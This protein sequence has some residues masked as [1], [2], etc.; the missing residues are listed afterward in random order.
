M[1]V[2]LLYFDGCPSVPAAREVLR[3]ALGAAGLP[4]AFEEV[5][6][7]DPRVPAT[8]RGWASP[9]ILVEGLDVG[10]GCVGTGPGCR[11]Y[12]TP[13]GV[14]GVPATAEIVAAL[15]AARRAERTP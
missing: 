14:R 10:G 13:D 3:E 15:I 1:R 6:V 9:T 5:D 11:V 4:V 8:L 2:Q 12:P 7:T